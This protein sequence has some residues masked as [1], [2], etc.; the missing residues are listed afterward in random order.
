MIAFRS[1]SRRR[2]QQSCRQNERRPRPELPTGSQGLRLQRKQCR[3]GSKRTK[4][5]TVVF[6][7]GHDRARWRHRTCVAIRSNSRGRCGPL[8]RS[9]RDRSARG[10]Y[11][12][13]SALARALSHRLSDEAVAVDS[14]CRACNVTA[15]AR[16]CGGM[17]DLSFAY[18]YI[19]AG[20][21]T[22]R[23]SARNANTLPSG[24]SSRQ[25]SRISGPT[26]S[27]AHAA[28]ALL[29]PLA[30]TIIHGTGAAFG[31]DVGV[32]FLLSMPS[33][34]RHYAVRSLAAQFLGEALGE[35]P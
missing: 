13:G 35:P 19:S 10:T 1:L 21:S 4:R 25:F 14:P 26:V 5:C 6:K 34:L 2:R 12:A 23:C 30:S 20:N 17:D 24:I 33:C 7:R 16:I 28:A 9:S 29:S 22:P 8:R 15:A 11:R 3:M 27:P 18:G 32:Q 31:G